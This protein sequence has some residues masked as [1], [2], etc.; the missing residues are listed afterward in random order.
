M[1]NG[2]NKKVQSNQLKFLKKQH[3]F[4][5]SNQLSIL[6]LTFILAVS[7]IFNFL[8]KYFEK[9]YYLLMIYVCF[10]ISGSGIMFLYY[11]K[12]IKR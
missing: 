8:Y 4:E 7:S 2:K 1:T 12:Y 5:K 11:K 3:N 10:L 9:N 6:G